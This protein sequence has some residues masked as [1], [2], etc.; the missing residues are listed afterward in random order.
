MASPLFRLAWTPSS[1]TIPPFFGSHGTHDDIIPIEDSIEFYEKLKEKRAAEVANYQEQYAVW[2]S[3]C[4]AIRARDT[5]AVLPHPPLPLLPDLDVFV[6]VPYASH[7]Y[8]N[9][10]SPRGFA[11]NDTVTVWLASLLKAHRTRDDECSRLQLLSGSSA[12]PILPPDLS[13]LPVEPMQR[14]IQFERKQ[15]QAILEA[16]RAEAK[17]EGEVTNCSTQTTLENTTITPDLTTNL[18]SNARFTLT[19]KL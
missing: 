1:Q 6:K 12:G 18:T 17:A 2:E 14:A 15:V 10:M 5:N 11:L 4:A 7:A 19:P 16:E 3:R 13:R 8:N 9:L